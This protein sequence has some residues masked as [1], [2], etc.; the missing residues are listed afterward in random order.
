MENRIWWSLKLLIEFGNSY[1]II[2]L[3]NKYAT[4][5]VEVQELLLYKNSLSLI[6]ATFFTY[7]CISRVN[8]A[9]SNAKKVKEFK[10]LT[11]HMQ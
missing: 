1:D 9:N 6:D 8:T 5:L 10:W 7:H 4:R 2:Q 3:T 11:L